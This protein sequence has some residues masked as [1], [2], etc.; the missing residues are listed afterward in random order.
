MQILVYVR[1][2]IAFKYPGTYYL[3]LGSVLEDLNFP[4]E[5]D[6][7][8][9]SEEEGIEKPAGQIFHRAI[10]N[11]NTKILRGQNPLDS[12]GCLHIG[13]ELISDYEGAIN[14]GMQALLLRRPGPEGVLDHRE[15]NESLD[16][17]HVIEGLNDAVHL[18]EYRNRIT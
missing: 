4:S 2:L 5:M 3:N 18:I 1:T 17:V 6:T 9:L 15:A 13:D 14:A 8:V 7:I 11:V 16:G 10:D 12:A